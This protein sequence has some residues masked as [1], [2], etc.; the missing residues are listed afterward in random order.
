MSG[1]IN[2]EKLTVTI[3][4]ASIRQAISAA[5][6][7][8]Q[9]FELHCPSTNSTAVYLGDDGVDAT[10]IPR[11]AGSTS[12]FTSSSGGDLIRGPYFDLANLYVLS[13]TVGDTVIVM[14]TRMEA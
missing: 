6:I 8:T 9:Q 14:Y 11:T 13:A 12:A 4:V 2:F 10:W 3:A 7:R 1:P 5:A